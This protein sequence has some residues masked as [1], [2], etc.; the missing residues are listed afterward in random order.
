LDSSGSGQE[1]VT[2]SYE[3]GN[4]PFGLHERPRIC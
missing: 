4:A 3:Y 1:P 2:V